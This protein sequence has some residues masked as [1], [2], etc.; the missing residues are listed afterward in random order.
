M[1][2]VVGDIVPTS[3]EL[4]PNFGGCGPLYGRLQGRRHLEFSVYTPVLKKKI[5]KIL[6]SLYAIFRVS[7]SV[8]KFWRLHLL[9]DP[10]N[11]SFE[12]PH[13]PT[14]KWERKNKNNRKIRIVIIII[15]RK[16]AGTAENP[17]ANKFLFVTSR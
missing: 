16:T 15:T 4:S 7:K 1:Y 14:H 12:L 10:E 13:F 9:R 5:A 3:V 6:K 8:N 11:K 17:S 2:T